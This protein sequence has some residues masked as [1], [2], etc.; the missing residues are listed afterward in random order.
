M[1][2]RGERDDASGRDQGVFAAAHAMIDEG[3]IAEADRNELAEVVKW[4]DRILPGGCVFGSRLPARAIFWFKA[5]HHEIVQRAWQLVNLLKRHE[6]PIE[7]IKTD[8]PGRVVYEDEMQI[9]A[10]PWSVTPG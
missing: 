4:F 3:R 8:R 2:H 1:V 6:M 10:V 7:M 9:A 5:S